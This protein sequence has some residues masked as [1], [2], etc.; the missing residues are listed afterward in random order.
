ML[1]LLVRL[2]SHWC[3]AMSAAVRAYCRYR[4]VYG[5]RVYGAGA[6]CAHGMRLELGRRNSKSHDVRRKQWNETKCVDWL[7]GGV[8]RDGNI[9][10][11]MDSSVHSDLR[12]GGECTRI[13]GN[14][15]AWDWRTLSAESGRIVPRAR[16]IQNR[17]QIG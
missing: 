10:F 5:G 4:S 16:K 3:C 11:A 1:P 17:R 15:S 14:V 7:G 2:Y 13:N 9:M 8:G 6:C 12:L